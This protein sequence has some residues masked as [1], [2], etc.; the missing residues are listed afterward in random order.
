MDRFENQPPSDGEAQGAT[1]ASPGAPQDGRDPEHEEDEE[2]EVEEIGIV[3]ED[4]IVYVY[5]SDWQLDL[6]PEEARELGQALLDAA[7]DAEGPAE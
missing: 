6:A 4:G 2:G 5:G 1:P 7:D 3:A